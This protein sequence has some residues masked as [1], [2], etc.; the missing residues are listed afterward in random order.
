MIM[1]R[2]F[3]Q[4]V[5]I[6]IGMLASL[7]LNAETTISIGSGTMITSQ[8][9]ASP[10]NISYKSLRG[11][12]VVTAQELNGSGIFG[13][14]FLTKIGLN[15]I[16]SPDYPLINFK[17]RLADYS[18]DTVENHYNGTLKTVYSNAS[19]VPTAGGFDMLLLNNSF[20]W[21]GYDNVLIDFS[22]GLNE[23][24]S[25]S[26][27]LYCTPMTNGFRYSVSN[28]IYQASSTTTVIENYRPDLSLCFIPFTEYGWSPFT[29][30]APFGGDTRYV[31]SASIYRAENIGGKGTITHLGWNLRTTLNFSIPIKVY[32]KTVTTT[33]FN[34]NTRNWYDLKNGSTEVFNGTASFG[35][36]G[37]LTI[38]ISDY[39]YTGDNLLVMCETIPEYAVPLSNIGFG[40]A[41]TNSIYPTNMQHQQFQANTLLEYG[42]A[43]MLGTFNDQLP[44]IVF[45][46]L[47][48]NPENPSAE[49]VSHTQIDLS[50]DQNRN[51][52]GVL[53]AVGTS[54][55]PGIPLEGMDYSAGDSLPGGGIVVY[56]GASTSFSHTD[57]TPYTEY[58]YKIWSVDLLHYS[59]GESF[60][61]RTLLA[62]V[63]DYPMVQTFEDSLFPPLGWATED[64]YSM[65]RRN[66]NAG[67][68]DGSNYSVSID[69]LS[70]PSGT[71][72]SFISPA[73]NLTS[74]TNPVLSF[75]YAL[76]ILNDEASRLDLYYSTDDGVSYN[77]LYS[78]T[79]NSHGILNTYGCG[80]IGY[81][82]TSGQWAT[83]FLPLPIETNRVKFTT[84]SDSGGELYI[85][86]II[87]DE[88]SALPLLHA[89]PLNKDF[90]EIQIDNVSN[91]QNLSVRNIGNDNLQI[92]NI[93]FTLNESSQYYL[94]GLDS[95][96]VT[97][98][99]NEE[100]FFQVAYL[101]TFVGNYSAQVRIDYTNP[102]P[103]FFTVNL[104][105]TGY[106]VAI[107]EL[108][109]LQ[110]WEIYTEDE[111]E[112]W[113]LVLNTPGT[114]CWTNWFDYDTFNIE[115]VIVNS[116]NKPLDCWY[117]SLPI[118]F[119]EGLPCTIT[120]DYKVSGI[121][122]Q[123]MEVAVTPIQ[124][125]PE[126][127]SILTS[128]TPIMNTTYIT[129]SSYFTAPAS[130][131]YYLG[132]HANTPSNP[133]G[134][135]ELF[136]DNIKVMIPNSQITQ[137]LIENSSQI[138]TLD[139]LT[140]QG[141]EINPSISFEGLNPGQMLTVSIADNPFWAHPNAGLSFNIEST[142][143]S[144]V[145]MTLTH[146]LGFIP[147][148]IAYRIGSG[149]L[150]VIDNPGTWTDQTI[151]FG[152]I[153]SKAS[154][155]LIIIFPKTETAILP[156]EL[157]N[158]SAVMTAEQGVKIDWAT[159]S[160]TGILGYNILRSE[161]EEI[162]SAQRIN[163]DL[164]T[165]NS[166]GSNHAEYSYSDTEF[167][168]DRTYYY[169]LESLEIDGNI[170]FYGPL[171]VDTSEELPGENT[172]DADMVTN[173]ENAFPNPFNPDT[174]ISYSLAEKGR[175][176]IDIFN[177]K[178]Q[179][180]CTYEKSHDSAG[181]FTFNWDGK[182]DKG[183]SVA[184]GILFYRMTTGSYS[185]TKKMVLI[186]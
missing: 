107:R 7:F 5:L 112:T 45:G 181:R 99:P 100:I 53:I 40:Y 79:G 60:T 59:S 158:F 61:S 105:G 32:L 38:D 168:Q 152:P 150:I 64:E 182:N 62:P 176:R 8:T 108:P 83:Q 58:Y 75:D 76:A 103:S 170:H 25:D 37:W 42:P 147:E 159:Q 123:S 120:Y 89:T 135:G 180:L 47:V 55:Y 74:L 90:N 186:K 130:G 184:S 122:Q 166:S 92:T 57:L 12:M 70:Y 153:T 91:Y 167:V 3:V 142:T 43:Y 41:P 164:I 2:K 157:S 162:E 146:N 36:T 97:L 156:V 29:Q 52:N 6:F 26:G 145:S 174:T 154:D 165:Q 93:D 160:E 28:E 33:Y 18:P 128:I 163:P 121:I 71:S 175:V 88:G 9:E 31:G 132:F 133:A 141:V 68:Y 110:N 171:L 13:P 114:P 85:D 27:R 86:N 148:T 178:G 185:T 131:L 63:S 72:G 10:I 67:G 172:P 136:L 106:D 65:W 16:E 119:E 30:G 104:T 48:E 14:V 15:I 183:A 179:L 134:Y 24:N 49:A 102:E 118:Y 109:Y 87:F 95:Y 101:P 56:N 4:L 78:M 169:W 73:L 127:S 125:Y 140:V 54:D 124:S 129:G 11:Q 21:Q 50:W 143:L 81:P 151:N 35:S 84:V 23:Q 149:N 111:K 155:D 115:A 77:L 139:P 96:P 161:L 137:V 44:N 69:F 117:N 94:T 144:G 39:N 82:P 34:S 17:V 173:L 113:D 20:L 126:F 98:I 116:L 19:Y 80:V 177:I 22:Y 46:G 138:V 51:S 66:N 1:N